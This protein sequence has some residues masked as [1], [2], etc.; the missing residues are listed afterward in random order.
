MPSDALAQLERE[1]RAIGAPRPALGEIGPDRIEAVL[2]RVLI[3]K[4]EV[5]EDRHHRNRHRVGRFLVDRHAGRAV[6]MIDPKDATGFLC[7]RGVGEQQARNQRQPCRQCPQTQSHCRS[8]SAGCRSRPAWLPSFTASR[9]RGKGWRA[10]PACATRTGAAD[11]AHRRQM[12]AAR[13]IARSPGRHSVSAR[14]P[15]FPDRPAEASA[16]N[17]GCHWD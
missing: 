16:A 11:P 9:P 1:P 12:R 10:M 14:E 5:V 17:A 3:V 6:A 2:R 8:P 7:E 13:S 15:T 4:H